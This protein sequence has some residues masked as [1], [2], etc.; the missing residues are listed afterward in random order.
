M[1]RI[2]IVT[3]AWHP[4]VN[5]V[6]R[7][8]D[9]TVRTLRQLGH[10]VEVLA[11]DRFTPVPNFAYPEIPLCWP[12]P[13]RV[14]AVIHQFQPHH[15]HIAT[16]GPIGVV[17]RQFAVNR[18]WRFST[19]YHTKF[20]E[21]ARHLIGLPETVGY[22]FLRWFHAASSSMM[23]ATPSLEAELQS[24]G[25]R[26][27]MRRWSRGVDLG[28]FRPRPRTETYPRPIQLYV[29][30]VS[31]EKGLD[32]FLSL[33]SPGTKLVVGD[34]PARAELQAKYADAVFLG[35]RKGESLAAEYAN[36][37]VFVFPSRTDTFGLVMIEAMACGVPV[38]AYPVTGPIDIVTNPRCG[39]LRE[40]LGEAITVAL[41]EG[42]REV[43][44]TEAS[45]YTWASCT[46]QFLANVVERT[47]SVVHDA[48]R[49]CDNAASAP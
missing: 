43:C 20:P 35:Y 24:R 13:H 15:L 9:T 11:P 12:W 1:S 30:R 23:V 44:A 45:R 22:R 36:A 2:L 46:Q 8:L 6:V 34:G 27:P 3:D 18:G 32:D 37:D 41:R 5:G 19:S 7:T 47:A 25:F 39:A 29:G 21:Y 48:R 42:V 38:A 17:V 40:N 4:Q 16:E 28:L 14:Q 33:K 49:S 31:A 26:T 10:L